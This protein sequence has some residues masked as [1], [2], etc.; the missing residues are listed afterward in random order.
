MW[1][2]FDHATLRC[3]VGRAR[4]AFVTT[5]QQNEINLYIFFYFL[6]QQI[7]KMKSTYY[8]I[9]IY[10]FFLSPFCVNYY[11]ILGIF[12]NWPPNFNNGLDGPHKP[13]RHMP[14]SLKIRDKSM[15]PAC[16]RTYDSY[17]CDQIW[18]SS[19]ILLRRVSSESSIFKNNVRTMSAD[20]VTM[21]AAA[22]PQDGVDTNQPNHLGLTRNDHCRQV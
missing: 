13:L 6:L 17:T 5:N 9:Y 19:D 20:K 8:S 18:K 16:R 22:A 3:K 11:S 4:E 12:P 1:R 7:N 10:T 21:P 2:L 14:L 15:P